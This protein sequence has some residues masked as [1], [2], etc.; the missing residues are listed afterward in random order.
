MSHLSAVGEGQVDDISDGESSSS[1]EAAFV[2]ERFNERGEYVL[3]KW[4]ICGEY[5]LNKLGICGE[6]SGNKC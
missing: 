3:N 6:H 2:P 4:R 5:V 1:L